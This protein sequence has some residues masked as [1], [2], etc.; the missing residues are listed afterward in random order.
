MSLMVKCSLL[1][2]KMRASAPAGSCILVKLQRRGFPGLPPTFLCR[3]ST[4]TNEKAS[5][6][7]PKSRCFLEIK[8]S[9]QILKN[10]TFGLFLLQTL[11]KNNHRYIS[12]AFSLTFGVLIF[13]NRREER[14]VHLH[15]LLTAMYDFQTYLWPYDHRK[16]C[17][18]TK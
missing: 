1:M 2:H 4:N 13:V 17:R 8:K 15:L 7:G 10:N 11:K 18:Q 5:K 16:A 14:V 12:L 9:Q 6:H 3:R